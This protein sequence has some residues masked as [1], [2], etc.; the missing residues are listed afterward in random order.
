MHYN[1]IARDYAE[2]LRWY[3]LAAAQGYPAALFNVAVF[4][5]KGLGIPV[6][7]AAAIHW[8]KRAQ[9]AGDPGAAAKVRLLGARSQSAPVLPPLSSLQ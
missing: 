8:Y 3:Q 9:A 2:A 6:D 4:H 5:E 7:E 1:G